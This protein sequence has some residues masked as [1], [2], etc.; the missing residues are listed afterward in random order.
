VRQDAAAKKGT[1]LLLDEAGSGLLSAT[2]V[3]EKRLEILADHL[4]E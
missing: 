2:R 1:E 3:S 4:V